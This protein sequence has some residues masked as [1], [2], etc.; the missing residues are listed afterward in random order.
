MEDSF[1]VAIGRQLW[2][3]SPIQ[4]ATLILRSERDFWSRPEDPQQ[5]AAHLVHAADVRVVV[6]PEAT[7]HVHLDR[8]ER[9]RAHFLDEVVSFLSQS[10]SGG[11]A[12]SPK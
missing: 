11:S 12:R 8:P 5:L 4:A 2:D 6:I 10:G 3:A 1:Y 7:H 9:G